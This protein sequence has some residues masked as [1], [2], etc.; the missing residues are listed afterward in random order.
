[1]PNG[2][3]RTRANPWPISPTLQDSL[4]LGECY[5]VFSVLAIPILLRNASRVGSGPGPRLQTSANT[6]SECGS[7]ADRCLAED[8]LTDLADGD[9]ANDR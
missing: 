8:K 6:A 5:Y 9:V 3:L 2:P 1:M 4:A 7:S